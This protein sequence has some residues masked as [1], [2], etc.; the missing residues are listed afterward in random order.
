[1]RKSDLTF[2]IEVRLVFFNILDKFLSTLVD[3]NYS[4]FKELEPGEDRAF[5]NYFDRE[6][7]LDLYQDTK[8]LDFAEKLMDTQLFASFCDD[9]FEKDVSNFLIYINNSRNGFDF[10]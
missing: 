9:Y 6:Q 5:I 7:F 2:T 8:N 1:M 4:C 10:T 3:E